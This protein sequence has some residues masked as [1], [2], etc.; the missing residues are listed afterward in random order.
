MTTKQLSLHGF[1]RHIQGELVVYIWSND[2]N[3]QELSWLRTK[4][5]PQ[6]LD[7]LGT[8]QVSVLMALG[9]SWFVTTTELEVNTTFRI[10]SL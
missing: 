8:D 4:R 5:S 3:R 6:L 10:T 1:L 9:T 7:L 2:E